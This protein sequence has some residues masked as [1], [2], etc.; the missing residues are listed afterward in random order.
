MSDFKSK[1]LFQQITDGLKGMD[2]K[3]KKDIQKKV[4]NVQWPSAGLLIPSVAQVAT[5]KCWQ[6]LA[7]SYGTSATH[8]AQGSDHWRAKRLKMS[9]QLLVTS[10][11]AIPKNCQRHRTNN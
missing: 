1:D 5:S 11:G 8:P 2:E 9:L 10:P 7:V 4:R 6:L 3:E